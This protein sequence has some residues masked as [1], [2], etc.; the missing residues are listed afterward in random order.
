MHIYDLCDFDTYSANVKKVFTLFMSPHTCI[1]IISPRYLRSL[2]PQMTHKHTCGLQLSGLTC[3]H[4]ACH[5]KQF[6][7]VKYLC[8]KGGE[9]LL[10]QSANVSMN[11]CVVHA[12]VRC[13]C[14]RETDRERYSYMQSVSVGM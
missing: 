14:R 3:L 13:M 5:E 1:G 7:V 9:K 2:L 12:S 4:I 8:E 6:D 11:V 10:M